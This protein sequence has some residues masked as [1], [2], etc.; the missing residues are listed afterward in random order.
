MVMKALKVFMVA[1]VLFFLLCA[2]AAA[3]V[4]IASLQQPPPTAKLRVFVTALTMESKFTKRPVFWPV[5]PEEFDRKQKNAID[6]RLR[7]QGIYEVVNSRDIRTVIGDQKIAAWEWLADDGALVRKVGR[8][9]HADYALVS[10]RSFTI[11]LQFDTRFINLTTGQE[12]SASGYV[13]PAMFR[14]MTDDQKK[15]A[16]AE[17]IK[18]Q[19]RQIFHDAKNDLIRT[20]IRKGRLAAKEPAAMSEPALPPV[21]LQPEQE[22][23]KEAA[24]PQKTAADG[25][26]SEK[27]LT[28]EKELE[29]A[30]AAGDDKT[31]KSRLVVYDFDA[32]E[33]MKVVGLILAEALREEF[34]KLGGFVLVNREN[35]LKIMD[36]YKLQQTSLVDEKQAVKVGKWLA[37]NEA[38]T[39]HLAM[40]GKTSILQVKRVDIKTLGTLALGSLKCP[41]GRE[42]ELLDQMRELARQLTQTK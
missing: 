9:L 39:G 42:D 35:I 26:L 40:L 38:V 17:V 12:F 25:H 24:R 15:Q 30:L 31:D 36:E 4:K 3:E 33:R 20:A 23:Q 18:I 19:F 8:A 32:A 16:G 34:H 2:S 6:E 13:P 21:K 14:F 28:F 11:H 37:A 29:Q 5:S 41:A 27:Q 10:Q 22:S 1:A 7:Q